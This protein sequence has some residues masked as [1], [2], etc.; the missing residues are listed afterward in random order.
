MKKIIFL[1]AAA[2]VAGGMMTSC[3]EDTQP[4]LEKPT[5]F[6]LNTPANANEI[7]VLSKEGEAGSTV[8]FTVSQPNYGLGTPT[9]YVVQT[10]Y[11]QDF[12]ELYSIP[13]VGTQAKISVS[14]TDFSVA[15][16]YLSGIRVEEDEANFTN[17]PR[18]V[19]VRVKAYIPNCDYSEIYSN[20]I[21]MWAQPFFAVRVPA[22]IWLIGTFE[23]PDSW[24]IDK[25][26]TILD[27]TENGIGSNI[28][29]G[30]FDVPAGSQSFRFYSVLGDWENNSIGAGADGENLQ[31]KGFGTSEGQTEEC[32][33]VV[34]K[35]EKEGKGNFVLPD[36]KGGKLK[37]TVDLNTSKM[38]MEVISITKTEE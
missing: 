33:I 2:T 30:I 32:D 5:E 14:S 3:K 9:H 21:S 38:Y 6:V 29:S 7:T 36:W 28:Y 31:F 10:S 13:T 1:M 19:Y 27:E 4:R 8:E 37:I 34:G 20:V 15:L 35:A 24:N 18:K 26:T 17:E 11:R 25:A 12:K 22:K 16:N 23:L